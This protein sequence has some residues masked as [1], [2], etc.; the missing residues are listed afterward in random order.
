MNS[1][2]HNAIIAENT[3]DDG[4]SYKKGIESA[5]ATYK[6]TTSPKRQ[7]SPR[8]IAFPETEFTPANTKQ[9]HK[10][11]RH[12]DIHGNI[13]QENYTSIMSFCRCTHR[14]E[15]GAKE[16]DIEAVCINRTVNYKVE[17]LDNK[18]H[19]HDYTYLNP[20]PCT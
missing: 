11:Y 1:S 16:R 10:D 4:F 3:S 7:G 17:V 5:T 12:D 9:E 6:L 13:R 14:T 8:V 19:K 20:E 15:K 18:H 2:F